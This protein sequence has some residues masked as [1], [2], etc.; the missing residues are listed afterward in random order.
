MSDI[1]LDLWSTRDVAKVKRQHAREM[2]DAG[3]SMAIGH[4]DAVRP[5]WSDRALGYVKE[6]FA[7]NAIGTCEQVRQFAASKGFES[8]PDGRAWGS[9]MVGACRARI[10]SKG[11]WTTAT[12]PKVHCNPVR[13]WIRV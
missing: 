7:R 3:I 1:Q 12:D 5:T 4:A 8:P 2:R 9:V 10:V 6:Y 13:E 11:G